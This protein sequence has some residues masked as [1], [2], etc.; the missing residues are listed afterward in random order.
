MRKRNEEVSPW[1]GLASYEDPLNA[2]EEYLFCGR[3]QESLE[4]AKLIDNNLFVTVYGRTG[5]GKTSLLNAGVF[6]IIRQYYY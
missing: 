1:R 4:V 2:K 5:I 3:D 6:P